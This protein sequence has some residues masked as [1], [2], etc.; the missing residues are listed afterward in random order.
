MTLETLSLGPR[1]RTRLV[2]LHEG[3]GCVALWRD[4]PARLSAATGL[5][6]FIYSR[7][8]YGKSPRVELPRKLTYMH[9]EAALLPSILR[10]HEI[11]LADAILVGHS[12]GA[13]IALLCAATQPVCG[14]VL[15]APHV[16]T[17]EVGLAAIVRAREAFWHGD[18]RA[19]LARHHADVEA[20][21]WGWNGPWLDPG[22]RSWNIESALPAVHAPVLVIQGADDEYGTLAQVRAIE[23]QLGGP[24][25]ALV[26]DQCGH[27]PH[28]DRAD[29]VVERA[30]AFARKLALPGGQAPE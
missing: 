9:E 19:R 20:A 16:F 23:R 27:S 3:L 6:A 2:F 24:V 11:S 29:A 1:S 14:L 30:A 10:T 13:S 8:G 4:F 7:A 5:G 12:D 26:L 18:L 15:E 25:A 22:F 28:K 17:E 21:F